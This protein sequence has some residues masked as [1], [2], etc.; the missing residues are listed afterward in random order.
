MAISESFF[1]SSRFWVSGNKCQDLRVR[2]FLLRLPY[3]LVRLL[4]TSRSVPAAEIEEDFFK[5]VRPTSTIKGVFHK[6]HGIT[7]KK[8]VVSC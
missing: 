6:S 3:S 1:G 8:K 4:V 7:S 2:P 5:T